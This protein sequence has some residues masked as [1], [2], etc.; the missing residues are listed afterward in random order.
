MDVRFYPDHT[1]GVPQ[2]ARHVSS[3][4]SDGESI[5]YEG[6]ANRLRIDLFSGQEAHVG[7]LAEAKPWQVALHPLGSILTSQ[8]GTEFEV[9]GSGSMISTFS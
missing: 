1:Q 8:C 9:G 3:G 4:T 5:L 7:E 2:I 6:P